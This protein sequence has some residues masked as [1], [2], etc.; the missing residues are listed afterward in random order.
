M[1]KFLFLM[2]MV[3]RHFHCPV[4]KWYPK[5]SQEFKSH[6]ICKQ[7][8]KQFKNVSD[9]FFI[10]NWHPQTD[11][12]FSTI[13]PSVTDVYVLKSVFPH[14]MIKHLSTIQIECKIQTM[15]MQ[16]RE[17]TTFLQPSSRLELWSYSKADAISP[18][19]GFYANMYT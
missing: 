14:S 18:K 2:I 1:N 11:G 5:L 8:Y 15:V 3:R 12:L 6:Q 10:L 7:L 19:D 9:S 4:P 13:S 17:S 16:K